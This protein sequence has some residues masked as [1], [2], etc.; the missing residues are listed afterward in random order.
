[1]VSNAV[2]DC[3]NPVNPWIS[4]V[5]VRIVRLMQLCS[6]QFALMS[7]MAVVRAAWPLVVL[8]WP[9]CG[10]LSLLA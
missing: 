5:C 4:S 3:L 1:M 10:T 8:V 7:L 6:W 9:M 2:L